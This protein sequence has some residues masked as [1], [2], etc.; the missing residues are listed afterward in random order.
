MQHITTELTT[1]GR[2]ANSTLGLGYSIREIL[3]GDHVEGAVR[4]ESIASIRG[5][6]AMSPVIEEYDLEDYWWRVRAALDGRG[7]SEP[8]WAG[9]LVQS[10][11]LEAVLVNE[12][13]QLLDGE[14][15]NIY[16]LLPE[17]NVRSANRM[18]TVDDW[19]SRLWR[20]RIDWRLHDILI[21]RSY[22]SQHE[23]SKR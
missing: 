12:D 16:R 8:S 20:R 6:A 14:I 9:R 3:P 23:R 18:W 21:I 4:K 19:S 7:G 5:D 17:E 1:V 10:V 22:L 2:D 15:E 11:I 13:D